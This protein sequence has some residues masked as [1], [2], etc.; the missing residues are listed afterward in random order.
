VTVALTVDVRDI[1]KRVPT[2]V[3]AIPTV[4]FR[5]KGRDRIEA[6][7]A[8]LTM[9]AETG[10]REIVDILRKQGLQ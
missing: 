8:A 5:Q 3:A 9:A 7:N 4:Q 2:K 10:T 6:A 1:K